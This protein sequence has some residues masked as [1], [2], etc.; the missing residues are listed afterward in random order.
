MP[1][2]DR[3]GPNGTGPRS[4]RGLGRC[5]NGR[6]NRKTSFSNNVFNDFSDTESLNK[7]YKIRSLKKEKKKNR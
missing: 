1:G 4:G 7:D 3:T 6:R 5:G 2:F